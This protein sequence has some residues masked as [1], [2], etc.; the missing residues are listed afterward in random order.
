MMSAV[1]KLCWYG[2]VGRGAEVIGSSF[3]FSYS[4]DLAE[5]DIFLSL[6]AIWGNTS[7]RENSSRS[8]HR[9]ERT[10]GTEHYLRQAQV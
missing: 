7:R 4:N 9:C 3:P 5:N 10:R 2:A 6:V 1:L 8:R